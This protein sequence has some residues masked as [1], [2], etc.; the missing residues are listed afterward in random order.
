MVMVIGMRV[1]LLMESLKVKGNIII[2][3]VI[4]LKV[5]LRME[6]LLDLSRSIEYIIKKLICLMLVLYANK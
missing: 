5:Y 3:M 6:N 4:C 1:T 2:K